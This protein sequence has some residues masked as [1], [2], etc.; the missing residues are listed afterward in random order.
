MV[1][2]LINSL[3]FLVGHLSPLV[4][5]TWV[6]LWFGIF[7]LILHARYISGAL[8]WLFFG[9][10]NLYHYLHLLTS[11]YH[12][13]LVSVISLPPPPPHPSSPFCSEAVFFFTCFH[14]VFHFTVYY[15]IS[16]SE[17][18]TPYISVLWYILYFVLTF[19][20]LALLRGSLAV[21]ACG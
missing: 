14:Y 16:W 7:W 17:R 11:H 21:L 12:F 6:R 1:F 5:Q 8:E 9:D 19:V 3:Q 18:F 13:C 4:V 20:V 2:F 10:E 15:K